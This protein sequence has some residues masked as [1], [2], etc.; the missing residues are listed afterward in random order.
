MANPFLDKA[1]GKR[2]KTK[3]T[4]GR[5]ATK[6]PRVRRIPRNV[7]TSSLLPVVSW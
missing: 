5:K 1:Y 3:A 4:K 6:R 7:P 2:T